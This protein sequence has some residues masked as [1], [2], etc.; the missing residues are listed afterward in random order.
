MLFR[1]KLRKRKKVMIG[2]V[3]TFRTS[4][5]FDLDERFDPISDI[6]ALDSGTEAIFPVRFL[7]AELPEDHIPRSSAPKYDIAVGLRYD[8]DTEPEYEHTRAT[9]PIIMNAACEGEDLYQ[10]KIRPR[11]VISE[12]GLDDFI[13]L[14][15]KEPSMEFE[16]EYLFFS[17]LLTGI[18]PIEGYDYPEG[19]TE[20]LA[21]L[22]RS[23]N[24]WIKK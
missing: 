7:C 9:E 13:A 24:P 23:V 20:L 1:R 16:V 14:Q 4:F 8:P 11:M 17:K 15:E 2:S 10:W 22:N 3:E 19:V 6:Y 18:Y 12:T 5:L 21:K